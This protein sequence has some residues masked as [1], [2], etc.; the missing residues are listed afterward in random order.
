MI[1]VQPTKGAPAGSWIVAPPAKVLETPTLVDWD[2]SH[3][4][5]ARHVGQT[6]IAVQ[7]FGT[8]ALL[9]H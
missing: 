1:V 7:Y 9:S 2:H 5:A 8:I 6:V 4:A 3:I